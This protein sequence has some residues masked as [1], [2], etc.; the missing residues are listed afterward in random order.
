MMKHKDYL[1]MAATV[2]SV[3]ED[4]DIVDALEGARCMADRLEDEGLLDKPKQK[5]SSGEITSDMAS[6]PI[7]FI[8]EVCQKAGIEA[9]HY[10]VSPIVDGQLSK[11][12]CNAKM[13]WV[14]GETIKS[15]GIPSLNKRRA[16]FEAA[17]GLIEKL[18][19]HDND[20]RDFC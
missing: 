4:I 17:R 11:F 20:Y 16:K 12:Q 7:G 19:D 13:V 14:D 18:F 5:E 1:L 3:H 10:T 6:N 9:P 8:Q 15:K 2:I